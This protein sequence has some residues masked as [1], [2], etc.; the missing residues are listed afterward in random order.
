MGTM[1]PTTHTNTNHDVDTKS[2]QEVSK[3]AASAHRGKTHSDYWLKK[4]FQPTYKTGSTL[5]QTKLFSIKIQY[6]GRRELFALETAIRA[7]AAKKARQIWASLTVVGWDETLR[8]FKPKAVYTPPTFRTVG[9]YI[10]FLREKNFYAPRTLHNKLTKFYTALGSIMAVVKT[11]DRY[12]VRNGGLKKWRAQLDAIPLDKLAPRVVEEWKNNVIAPYAHDPVR[13]TRKK[14]TIDSY[15]RTAK[16][17]FG[18]MIRKR[19]LDYG[20]TL[21]EPVPFANTAYLSRGR[22]AYRYRSR[23]DPYQLTAKA[24][25]ALPPEQLKVFLLALHVGMRRG[26]IDKLLWSQFDFGRG[27]LRIEATE[28]AALKTEGSEADV[29]LEAE[30]VDYFRAAKERARG[31]FV[32]EAQRSPQSPAFYAHYRAPDTYAQLCAWLRQNAT[33]TDKPIHTLRKEFGRLITEKMG[34]YAASLALRH[35]TTTVTQIYYADDTR[36]KLTG[37]GA[38]LKAA[39]VPPA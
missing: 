13:L 9:D 21:N 3:S 38:I 18:P 14:H 23:I 7:E 16:A 19:L 2:V 34:I 35:T 12:R 8:S 28:Y 37:L 29:F 24:L 4:V 30:L 31:I 25:S 6:R 36:P 5:K 22:S 33:P 26:E 32:I 39:S 20:V 15:I 10:A 27:V 11:S 17:M 1:T